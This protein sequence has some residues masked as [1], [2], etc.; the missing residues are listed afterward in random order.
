MTV[1]NVPALTLPVVGQPLSQS[2]LKGQMYDPLNFLLNPPSC[3]LTQATGQAF[4]SSAVTTVALDTVQ[5]DPWAGFNNATDVWT[6]PVAGMY[7]IIAT[8]GLPAGTS[9]GNRLLQIRVNNAALADG[10][11]QIEFPGSLSTTNWDGDVVITTRCN[12]GDAISFIAQQNSGSTLTS[13][14]ATLSCTWMSF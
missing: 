12:V 10:S 11:G 6:V 7:L 9:E 13:F 14:S 1:P 3:K 2:Y 4:T 8:L 5:W